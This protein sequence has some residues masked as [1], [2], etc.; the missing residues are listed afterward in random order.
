MRSRCS[1]SGPAPSSLTVSSAGRR[2]VSPRRSPDRPA[3]RG[4]ARSRS[5]SRAPARSASASPGP[6]PARP[7]RATTAPVGVRGD[8]VATSRVEVDRPQCLLRG[9]PTRSSTSRSSTSRAS[10]AASR[11]RSAS[12]SGSAPWRAAYSTLPSSA[13][14]GVRSSCEASARNRRSLARERSSA[15]EHPVEH[16]GELRRSRRRRRGSG[17]RRRGSAVRS[18]SL[19]RVGEP[20]QRPQPAARQQ[21]RGQRAASSAAPSP[22]SASTSPDGASVSAMSLVSEA[23][24]TAPPGGRTA[25]LGDRR[26]VEAER[27]PVEVMSSKPGAAV[28]P[29]PR[30]EP[31]RGQQPRAERQRAGE[32]PPAR[33]DHLDR[34]LAP[35]DR[36]LER[37]RMR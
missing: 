30:G 14:T 26:G 36:A 22:L 18:I 12:T 8:H 17:S 5:G 29:R 1:G 23:T 16:A 7:R 6:R 32:D 27:A 25:G 31:V 20:A 33:V 28:H 15:A 35:R 2:A 11:R 21:R 19:G 34:D 10:R 9:R 37:A 4:R 24:S 13:V 3:G